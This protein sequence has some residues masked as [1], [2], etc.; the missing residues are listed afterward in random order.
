M[1]EFVQDLINLKVVA[2]SLGKRQCA[3]E[4]L[5]RTEMFLVLLS[6]VQRFRLEPTEVVDIEPVFGILQTPAPSK[7]RLVTRN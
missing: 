1:S 4:A 5:A 7:W 6:I 3:G 2:F